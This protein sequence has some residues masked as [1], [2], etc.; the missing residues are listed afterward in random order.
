MHNETAYALLGEGLVSLHKFVDGQRVRVVES[1]K[2]IPIAD[3]RASHRHGIATD[4]APLPYKGY[5]GDSN[6]CMEI[7]QDER[8]R[9][10]AEVVTTF[11]AYQI[12]RHDG[13]G[14]LRQPG[15]SQSGRPL[16]MRLMI[17]DFIK[18]VFKG[19]E[20]LLVVRKIKSVG[21]MFVSEHH[22]ANV[23]QREDAKDPTL[24]YGSFSPSTLRSARG[25]AVAVSP[26]GVVHDPGARG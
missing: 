12:P 16:V 7:V 10:I 15:F 8:G 25:R 5:K 26:I 18:A 24:I 3:S 13:K 6:Y 21:T 9:W 14:R 22:E 19:R 23:R 11:D 4:G 17:G 2:V 1:L 20:R